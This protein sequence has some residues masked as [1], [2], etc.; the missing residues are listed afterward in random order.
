MHF[1]KLA[2]EEQ[3][4]AL[5]V[6]GLAAC[7]LAS[8]PGGEA[9]A[10]HA[11]NGDTGTAHASISNT[12][13]DELLNT[14]LVLVPSV[15]RHSQA[16]VTAMVA[17]RNVVIHTQNAETLK[18]AQTPA[19][20]WCLQSL[21]SSSRD[22]R[23]A[24]ARTLQ[25]YVMSR[26]T[27]KSSLIHDNRVVALDYSQSLWDKGEVTGQE[28]VVMALSHAGQVV[29][30]EELNIILLRLVEYLGHT[31]PYIS[32]LVYAELQRL[33]QALSTTPANLVRPFW[34]TVSIVIIKHF[35]SRPGIA[36]YLCDLLGLYIDGLLLLIEPYALPYL[37]LT[38]NLPIIERI[39][40]AH[41]GSTSAYHL[42]TQERN[43]INIL[44]FLLTQ[45][46]EDPEKMIAE[47]L[48][49]ISDDFNINDVSSW[50]GHYPVQIACELLKGI[51]DAG[52]SKSSRSYLA[53]QILVQLIDRK[54]GHASSRRS[55]NI[56]AFLE[57][58]VLSIVTGFTIV[59]NETE[60]KE[61]DV[62]KRRA[63][64]A[65]GEVVKL[66]K[67]R[68]SS[69]LPQICACLRSAFDK[70]GLCNTAFSSW[71]IMIYSLK[72]DDVEPLLDQ[73][74]AIVVKYWSSLESDKQQQAYKLISDLFS[75]RA[76]LMQR[77][78]GTLPSLK[79]IPALEGFELEINT[80]KSRQDDQSQFSAFVNRLQDEN[81]IVIE[82]TL[83]EVSSL[84]QRKQDFLHKSVL[85]EQPDL[86]VSDLTR[87]LLECSVKFNSSTNVSLLCGKCLG[88]IGCLDPSKIENI[89]ERKSLIVRSS[90]RKADDT[91]EFI[92]FFLENI[93]VPAFLS[94]PT[95]RAQGFLGWAMQELL[96]ICAVDDTPGLRPR[97][98]EDEVA[99]RKWTDLPES[100]RNILTPFLTS[101]Y[102]VV[103]PQP[104]VKCSYPIYRP[105]MSHADWLRTIVLDFLQR[106]TGENIGL[107]FG[108]CCRVI[109]GQDTV[110]PSFLL[111]YTV[112][113][114]VVFGIE[115]DKQ[116]VVQEMLNILNQPLH[117]LD[118]A[119]QDDVRL[120]SQSIF[121]VLDYMS[122]WL[123]EK[124][125]Q[126]SV[127]LG[128]A[129]RGIRDIAL[130]LAKEQ[131]DSLEKVLQSIPP[132]TLSRRAIDCRSYSRALVNWEQYI[133]KAKDVDPDLLLE[134]LQEIYAQIDEPDGV[135]G[136]SAQMHVFGVEQ[137]V[138]E[139]R[140]A[141]RWTAAQGWYEMQLTDHPDD[142]EA[143]L[144]LMRCLKESGQFGKSFALQN[145][146]L[147]TWSQTYLFIIL[148]A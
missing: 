23:L 91:I 135:E 37:V 92:F 122:K 34:R 39:A 62:E 44:S 9:A 73:T 6:L 65:L 29:A 41:G 93:L 100:I 126:Y 115:Q 40:A 81:L 46:S 98:H 97:E 26:G 99:Y 77:S 129:E 116:D 144:N 148:T 118:H 103:K 61:S 31:N 76:A 125:R 128:R 14:L 119:V 47:T 57:N 64:A 136:I 123:Q 72:D 21:R 49:S 60:V 86:L 71:A 84:L 134:R 54:P 15:S 121:E 89:Q 110:I 83:Q 141:G 111:P 142:T 16:R 7:E 35:T 27:D 48:Q 82:Q 140:K 67:S 69:S 132:D 55:G 4:K 20:E 18:L 12:Y 33:A 138:L 42:C 32:G 11:C 2:P 112:L 3:S 1:K 113:N 10:C 13:S 95:V 124:R 50:V 59:L 147:L 80:F 104:H 117:G 74:F 143:Q 70:K 68:I 87:A 131:I 58:F 90:F 45:P 96:K 107:T 106:A 56:A 102:Q 120:C 145:D 78:F 28:S 130:G 114:L 36:Q 101:K 19:G 22:M 94:A 17:L 75:K 146:K 51:G 53:L 79:G 109:Q 137:Q 43:L 139:H 30:D 127:S 133:R 25:A 105:G 8:P 88:A 85:R 108:I 52:D 5:K 66:G 24:S 38:R 63:V